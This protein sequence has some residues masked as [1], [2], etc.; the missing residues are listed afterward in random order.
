MTNVGISEF[1]KNIKH[2]SKVVE[3]EDL[4]IFSN[5]KPIMKVTSPYKNRIAQIKS[6]KGIAKT[7]ESF[8]EIMA[9]KLKEL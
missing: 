2:F 6:L 8:E 4:M 1:R 9:Y 3:K 7:K 5:G